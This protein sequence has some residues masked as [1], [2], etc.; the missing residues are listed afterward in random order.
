[1]NALGPSNSNFTLKAC[2]ALHCPRGGVSSLRRGAEETRTH[3]PLALH[4]AFLA[5]SP[6]RR[7][8]LSSPN[9]QTQGFGSGGTGLNFVQTAAR[10]AVRAGALRCAACT[11][12]ARGADFD[13]PWSSHLFLAVT[14]HQ[15]DRE[16]KNSSGLQQLYRQTLSPFS[17]RGTLSVPLRPSRTR[18]VG[19]TSS[20]QA[21]QDAYVCAFVRHER[22]EQLCICPRLMSPHESWV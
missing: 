10:S 4:A 2:S 20:A 3:C 21:P 1:M 11:G 15:S 8:I 18:F 17:P 22:Y 9:T 12:H 7:P 13:E 5:I 16:A 6:S 19:L 14:V